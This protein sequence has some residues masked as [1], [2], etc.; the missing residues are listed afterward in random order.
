MLKR[1]K[2]AVSR[3]HYKLDF[4]KKDVPGGKGRDANVGDIVCS[5]DAGSAIFGNC[6]MLRKNGTGAANSCT[7]PKNSP[8]SGMRKTHV[9]LKHRADLSSKP[10]KC[11]NFPK[12][13]YSV[14]KDRLFLF[15]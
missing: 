1:N 14:Q 3:S 4:D 15:H 2:N 6:T 8:F 7:K 10:P 5:F 13:R 11:T 9:S 12:Y